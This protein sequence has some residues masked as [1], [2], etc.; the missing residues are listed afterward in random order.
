[1]K[2][3]FEIKVKWIVFNWQLDKAALNIRNAVKQNGLTDYKLEEKLVH[4]K[5]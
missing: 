5:E 3:N 2:T 4:L 1:M